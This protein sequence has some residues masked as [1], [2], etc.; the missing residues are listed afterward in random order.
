MD[1]ADLTLALQLAFDA[2]KQHQSAEETNDPG[3][4]A[5]YRERADRLMN[6]ARKIL[7]LDDDRRG[8]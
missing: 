4:R 5:E 1:R 6:E 3:L 8:K 7:G 2:G